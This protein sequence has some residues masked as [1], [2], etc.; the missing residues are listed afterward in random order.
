MAKAGKR[1]D[2]GPYLSAALICERILTESDRVISA[3]RIVD[4]ITISTDAETSIPKGGVLPLQVTLLVS[5]KAGHFRGKQQLNITLVGP[6][7]KRK[8]FFGAELDFSGAG[9]EPEG[10]N[11]L[12]IRMHVQWDGPG[13]YWLEIS[14]GTRE[15]TRVPFRLK[16]ARSGANKLEAEKHR[17]GENLTPGQK[18]RQK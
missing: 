2:R 6:S 16:L 1:S 13:L 10:G 7:G 14:L 17:V 4:T 8:P 3:M 12:G 5:F 18:R 9:D 15:L 11:N